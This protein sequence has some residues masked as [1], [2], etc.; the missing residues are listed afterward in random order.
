MLGSNIHNRRGNGIAAWDFADEIQG[1]HNEDK[2]RSNHSCVDA[3]I[4]G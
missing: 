1:I 2:N 3:D 4:D